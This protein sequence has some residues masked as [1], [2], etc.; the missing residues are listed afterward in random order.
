[1][2]EEA[3][4]IERKADEIE[5]TILAL[6]R[7]QGMFTKGG[8]MDTHLSNTTNL[9]QIE[10]LNF[11]SRADRLVPNRHQLTHKEGS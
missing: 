3:D 2:E 10:A 7:L 1:M 8:E 5:C 6:D 4:L 11:R 9:L